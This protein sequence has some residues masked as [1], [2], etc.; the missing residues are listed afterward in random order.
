MILSAKDLSLWYLRRAASERERQDEPGAA[1]SR[2]YILPDFS[3]VNSWRMANK[4]QS[5][6]YRIHRRRRQVA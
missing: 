1:D 2:L 3:K 6:S 5:R 4:R